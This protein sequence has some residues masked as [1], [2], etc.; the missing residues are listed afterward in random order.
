M[1]VTRSAINNDR[2]PLSLYHNKKLQIVSSEPLEKDNDEWKIIPNNNLI[3]M[4]KENNY[5][6]E[7]I[8]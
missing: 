2:E 5:K 6:I 8:F 4:D 3:Y 1:I 7:S